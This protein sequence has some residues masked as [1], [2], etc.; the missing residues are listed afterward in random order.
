MRVVT[1]FKDSR[2]VRELIAALYRP[3]A[4]GDRP[5]PCAYRTGPGTDRHDTGAHTSRSGRQHGGG[6][7]RRAR[8]SSWANASE[9]RPESACGQ[10][11]TNGGR[12]RT[13]ANDASE[14]CN[15]KR[16]RLTQ[17]SPGWSERK[18]PARA[19]HTRHLGV[20][21]V[22]SQHATAGV[23]EEPCPHL[24]VCDS[25]AIESSGV[26]YCQLLLSALIHHTKRAQSSSVSCSYRPVRG[27]SKIGGVF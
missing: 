18:R 7:G 27:L 24:R 12:W 17:P 20:A 9:R 23:L 10:Q 25:N 22:T 13:R 5:C 14:P 2:H 11:D 15:A 4:A 26:K 3:R 16:A 1:A 19:V 8:A 21:Y 6:S